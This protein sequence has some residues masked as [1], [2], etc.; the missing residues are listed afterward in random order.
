MISINIYEIVLQCIN[1]CVLIW[2]LKRFMTKPLSNFLKERAESIK[3]NIQESESSR[4]E[5]ERILS[6]QKDLLK[7]AH[8]DAQEVRVKA[9]ASAKSE[10]ETTLNSAKDETARLIEN[11]K[12]EIELEYKQAKSALTQDAARLSIV[13]TEKLIKKNLSD[14]DNESLI[15]DYL[16]QAAN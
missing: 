16:A 4:S 6:E 2:L 8:L 13:L 1:I 7:K 9:E 5:A 10:R 3:L 14:T 11:A 15:K 12:K